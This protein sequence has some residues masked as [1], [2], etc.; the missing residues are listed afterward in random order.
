MLLHEVPLLMWSFTMHPSP[1]DHSHPSHPEQ[2]PL[3][4]RGYL[5][6]TSTVHHQAAGA[7]AP[8]QRFEE[9]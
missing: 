4:G 3:G 5:R 7:A 1:V 8:E 2:H 9:V 6:C